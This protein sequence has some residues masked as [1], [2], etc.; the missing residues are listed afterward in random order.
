MLKHTTSW[1]ASVS[2][3]DTY[4]G[5]T[6]ENRGCLLA[7]ETVLGVDNAKSGICYWR[8]S[9]AS[10]TLSGVTQSRFR[11]IYWRASVASETLTGVTQSKIGDV[12][13][14]ASEASETVLGVDNAKSGICYRYICMWD[15]TYAP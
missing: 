3:R 10:E 4:R 7:S 9:E 15:G 2:E 8:A 12:C 13:W 5:N 14:R 6:I 1:R 11:Y